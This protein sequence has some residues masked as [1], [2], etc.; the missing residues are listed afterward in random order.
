MK[1]MFLE[2]SVKTKNVRR[3]TEQPVNTVTERV[4]VREEVSVS[5]C[6]RIEKKKK[7]L[8]RKVQKKNVIPV[9]L[10]TLRPIK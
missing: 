5:T 9:S 7:I 3:D 8:S 2:I 6:M 1:F 10:K 4:A